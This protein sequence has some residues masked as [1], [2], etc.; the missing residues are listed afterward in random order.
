MAVP[1]RATREQR[2]REATSAAGAS[3]V[4]EDGMTLDDDGVT[5]TYTAVIPTRNRAGHLP[6]AVA[7]I[8]RAHV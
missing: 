4:Q 3:T 1:A 6:G 2:S 5:L 8:G 7:K